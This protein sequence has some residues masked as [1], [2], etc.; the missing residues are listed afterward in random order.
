MNITFLLFIIGLSMF[1][2]GYVNQLHPTCENNETIK[3]V[4]R[5][6]FDSLVVTNLYH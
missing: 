3:Y 4:P 2:L 1:I 6:V 5:D